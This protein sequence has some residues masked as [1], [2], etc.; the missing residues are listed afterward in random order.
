MT[1]MA[2]LG[3]TDVY[4]VT[5]MTMMAMLLPTSWPTVQSLDICTI[6]TPLFAVLGQT[7]VYVVTITTMV[8]MLLPN[9]LPTVQSHSSVP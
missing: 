5:I 6:M 1:L 9:L 8:T 7:D 3:Q 4:A 2:V